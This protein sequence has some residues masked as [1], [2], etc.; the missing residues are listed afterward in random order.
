MKLRLMLSAALVCLVAPSL[1]LAQPEG[2]GHGN[3]KKEQGQPQGQD[4]GKGGGDHKGGPENKGGGKPERAPAQQQP[5]QARPAPQ[6]QAQP[7]PQ[8]G[9]GPDRPQAQRPAP[10]PQPQARPDTR[11]APQASG[12][13]RGRGPDGNGPPGQLKRPTGPQPSL[14]TWTA[15]A[16]RGPQRDQSA[17]VWRQQNQS[18]DR[19]AV[20]RQQ[21]DWYRYD[22]SFTGFGFTGLRIGFFFVPDRGYISIPRQYRNR[23]WREGDYLP[24][25]FRT[26]SVSNP[27][28]YG[29]PRPPRYCTWVWLNGDVALI[30]RR[31]G[32]ILD[33]AR[34]VW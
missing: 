18:W 23:Q 32:Y 3:D 1:A 22:R 15:P 14:S 17:Q 4:K 28:R 11:P 8:R 16:A 20:W 34:R 12:P 6:P 25:W 13:G 9:G 5:S 2:K 7:Q 21:P 31:D 33:I 30:D 27:W 24:T 26:Y 10:A 29:L 19:T